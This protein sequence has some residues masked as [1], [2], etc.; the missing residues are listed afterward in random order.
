MAL[1]LTA[2]LILIAAALLFVIPPLLRKAATAAPAHDAADVN[3]NVLRDQLRELDRDLEAGTLDRPAYDSARRELLA[4]VI[5]AE[6]SEP[7]G[8]AGQS[9]GRRTAIAVAL[10]VPIVASFLYV[11]LGTPMA[12]VASEESADQ[13][14][15][16]A[17]SP[18]EIEAMVAG[19]AS[20]LEQKPDDPD[21]WAMLARSYNALGRY[22]EASEAY[23]R[24]V[25]LVPNDANIY[26]DYADT[27]GMALGKTLQGEPE[28]LVRQALKL[29]PDHFKALALAGT[30]AFERQD[31]RAAIASW[32]R[33]IALAPAESEIARSTV[34][35][36]RQ[37][38]ARIGT[39]DVPAGKAA[40][41]NGGKTIAGVV[42]LDPALKSQVAATDTV[43]I[44]ARAVNGPRAPL[45]VIQRQVKDLPYRFTLDDSSGM[46][47]GRKLSEFKEVVV[48]AR[49]SRSGSA[50]PDPADPQASS[51]V[52]APGVA[53]L[54]IRIS[55]PRK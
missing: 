54:T 24:L 39:R 5:E 12:L 45:A 48:S 9:G 47:G 36:I 29:D 42:E 10:F 13:S 21:G 23:A 50:T 28:K 40:S 49:I 18:A 8:A 2:A 51:G 37:A 53:G 11:L 16:H 55:P 4:R 22:Q 46:M 19:L 35:S 7:Q 15:P 43:F 1:F 27:L 30:A 17:A 52:V 20:R 44:F 25:K 33:I 26:A 38:Q 34:D 31:Y 6:Q 32:E 14:N 41:S 3:L